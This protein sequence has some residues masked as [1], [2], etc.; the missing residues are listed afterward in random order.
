MVF[1]YFILLILIPKSFNS[2]FVMKKRPAMIWP[3]CLGPQGHF[4]KAASKPQMEK[5][6]TMREEVKPN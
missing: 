4:Y 2:T 3:T 5:A 1:L 6:I